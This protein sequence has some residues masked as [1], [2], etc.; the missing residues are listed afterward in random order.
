MTPYIK[1]K[2]SKLIVLW[3]VYNRSYNWSKS[4]GILVS[5]GIA[6]EATLNKIALT[7][8]KQS[9]LRHEKAS[10]FNFNPVL[11]AAFCSRLYVTGDSLYLPSFKALT[12]ATYAGYTCS[13]V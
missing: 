4:P 5:Q 3:A 7:I 1:G 8:H 13:I 10:L 6:I 12:V 2:V 11:S 9:Y